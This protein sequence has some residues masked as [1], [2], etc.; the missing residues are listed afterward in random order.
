MKITSGQ[1]H[2]SVKSM[3]DEFFAKTYNLIYVKSAGDYIINLDQVIEQ[4]YASDSGKP[5]LLHF[6]SESPSII[7]S[8]LDQKI[9]KFQL[10]VNNPD[11]QIYIHT[12]NLIEK[13]DYENLSKCPVSHHMIN[14]RKYWVDDV[15][16]PNLTAWRFG[17]FIGRPTTPRMKFFYD[18]EK[19]NIGHLCFQSK[20]LEDTPGLFEDDGNVY[21]RCSLW[22][23]SL[24]EEE[25]FIGWYNNYNLPSFDNLQLEDMYDPDK[26]GRLNLVRE[27]WKYHIDIVFET[28]T[29]GDVFCPTEKIVRSL[30]TEKPFFVYAAPN[31]LNQLKQL[32][33]K[34]FDTLWDESYDEH[35][36]RLR[37]DQM[38][39]QVRHLATIPQA[40]FEKLMS[41]A[42]EITAHNKQV[43]KQINID[44]HGSEQA[45]I[46]SPDNTVT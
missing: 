11:Q 38:L 22:F 15:V 27:S 31:F 10:E 21:D 26:T 33:F 2:N 4:I 9:K 25:S 3:Q 28:F 29:V 20:L 14:C 43:L 35:Q 42:R 8:G 46:T 45:W 34:T 1:D 13:V 24:D 23:D 17:H 39:K 40:E 41:Q 6:M 36:L 5:I 19:Y 12:P 30:I 16:Y 32:G 18:L 37:Y 7:E 44:L